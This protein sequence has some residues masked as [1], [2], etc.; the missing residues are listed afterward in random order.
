MRQLRFLDQIL[1]RHPVVRDVLAPVGNRQRVVVN[2][3]AVRRR[4]LHILRHRSPVHTYLNVRHLTA[5]EKSVFAQ[6]DDI[7]GWQSLDVAGKQILTVDR[8]PHLEE[9]AEQDTIARLAAGTVRRRHVDGEVID[10]RRRV[11][12]YNWCFPNCYAHA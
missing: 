2:Y 12:L 5:G 3:D 9:G 1:H 6:P 10:R 8:N 4:P 11:R 7:P